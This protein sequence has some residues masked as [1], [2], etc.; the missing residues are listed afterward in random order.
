M[1]AIGVYPKLVCNH[2]TLTYTACIF[3][4]FGYP[5]GPYI[6]IERHK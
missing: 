3:L 6:G 2:A 1:A 5:F 4:V